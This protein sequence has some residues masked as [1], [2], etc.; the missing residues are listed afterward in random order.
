MK[1]W[2]VVVALVAWTGVAAAAEPDPLVRTAKETGRPVLGEFV[3]ETCPACDQL[4]PILA[5]VLARHPH[6]VRRVHDADKEPELAKKYGVKCVPVLVIVDP[7]GQVR[8]NQVGFWTAEELEAVLRE[9]G[10]AEAGSP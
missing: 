1:R 8:F 6:I 2:W 5:E 4:E 10:V 9:A 7:E 3:S